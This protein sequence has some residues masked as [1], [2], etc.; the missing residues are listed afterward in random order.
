MSLDGAGE[1]SREAQCIKEV[2]YSLINAKGTS[3]TQLQ[4]AINSSLMQLAKTNF[5]FVTTAVFS[6][7]ENQNASDQQK[8]QLL[9]LLCQVL[10]QRE[11]RS[12]VVPRTLAKN[13]TRL[14][15]ASPGSASAD[16]LCELAPMHPDLVLSEISQ[17]LAAEMPSFAL[18]LLAQ[19]A[20]TS[21]HSLSE[22]LNEVLS[23]C[24]SLLQGCRVMDLRLLLLRTWCSLCIAIV[25]CSFRD[26]D[27]LDAGHP[28][29]SRQFAIAA[30]PMRSRQTAAE[31]DGRKTTQ[32][33]SAVFALLMSSWTNWKDLAL[34]VVVI[35]TL[36]HLSLVIP[37][38]Q[39]LTNAD[40]LLEHIISLLSKQGLASSASP[41]PPFALMRGTC[42]TLQA[43]VDADRELLTIE[44]T[45]QTLWSGLF[46]AVVA[47]GPLQYLQ[48]LGQEALQ[49]Q[50]ELLRCMDVLAEN[51]GKE[52]LNFL[53]QKVKGHREERLAALLV[54]R[55]L[56]AG[57][58]A[59]TIV[60]GVQPLLSDSDAAVGLMLG[61]LLVAS[62]TLLEVTGARQAH[63][64]NLIGFVIRLTA[65]AQASEGEHA[66][67][68]IPKFVSKGYSHNDAPSAE[69][70]RKRAGSVLGQLAGASR[71][72]TNLVL[73]PLLL[74]ALINPSML[75]GLPVLCR[76]VT[77]MVQSERDAAEQ[78]AVSSGG[79][80]EAIQKFGQSEVLLLWMLIC[81]HAPTEPP[82]IGISILRCLESLAT[83][84]HPVLGQIWEAPSKRLQTLCGHLEEAMSSGKLEGDL[85]VSA[86]AQE[87]DFF[88]SALAD[89]DDLPGKL[90]EILC[91]FLVEKVKKD[92]ESPMAKP[93]DVAGGSCDLTDAQRAGVFNL[94]GICLRHSGNSQR[95]ASTLELL[96]S[97]ATDLGRTSRR[98]FARGLGVCA[99]RHLELTLTA[100]AKAAKPDPTRRSGLQSF[101]GKTSAVQTAEQLRATL[102]L[103]L[104]FCAINTP[105]PMLLQEKACERILKPLH[106]ALVQ[107]KSR[108]I[109]RH[110]VDAVR[111]VGDA[112]RCP[113]ERRMECDP[114]LT[115]CAEVSLP[116]LL[117]ALSEDS[118]TREVLTKYRNDLL[119]ALL[120]LITVPQDQDAEKMASFDELL[121]P[122]L[123]A[124]SSFTLLPLQLPS[125]LFGLLVEH[126]LQVLLVSL[127]IEAGSGGSGGV[128]RVKSVTSVM[129]ALLFH[130]H[131]WFGISKLLQDVHK[132][133]AK[134]HNEAVRW[135]CMQ[136]IGELCRAAPIVAV[137]TDGEGHNDLGDWCECLA[138][139]LPRVGDSS[140]AVASASIDCMQQLLARCEFTATLRVGSLEEYLTLPQDTSALLDEID[141]EFSGVTPLKEESEELRGDPAPVSQQLVGSLLQRLPQVMPAMV[142]QLMPA[143]HDVDSHAAMTGV[144]AMH[145]LLRS[146][147]LTVEATANIVSS[148][149]EEV[150][151][152]RHSSVR[153]LVLSC[154][155][156][157][158]MHHFDI[159]IEELLETGPDFNMS[160]MGALQVMAKENTLLL[161]L[162][163]HFAAI[164]NY[165]DPGPPEDPSRKVLAAT[166]ALGHLFTVNDST[167]G[168][169]VKKYFS[170]LFGTF[171]LRIGTTTEGLS[172]QQAAG[173][174]M[175]FLH[176]SQNDSMAMALEG[177]RL[178]KVTKEFYDEVICELVTLYCPHQPRRRET[179]LHFLQPFLA[180]QPEGHRVA[181]ATTMSQVLLSC[182][183]NP[184]DEEVMHTTLCSVVA[185]I[186]DP[187]ATVRKQAVRGLGNV[188]NLWHHA[189]EAFGHLTTEETIQEVLRQMCRLLSDEASAVRREAVVAMQRA[190]QVPSL[191]Q[192]WRLYLLINSPQ[193]LPL[194]LD[195]EDTLLRGASL[196]L[197]G[198]LCELATSNGN[199][200]QEADFSFAGIG[201]MPQVSLNSLDVFT[202]SLLM[203]VMQCTIRLED[204]SSAV[205]AAAS[206]CLRHITGTYVFQCASSSQGGSQE[207]EEAW[208]LL[209]RWEQA[210]MDFEQFIFP[211]M[212]VL[213]IPRREDLA[214]KR[215]QLCQR[216]L[217]LKPQ[218][219]LPPGAPPRTAAGFAAIALLRQLQHE[220]LRPSYQVC[221]ICEDL[222]DLLSIEDLETKTQA[223]RL[224]GLLDLGESS[225]KMPA[226]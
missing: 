153:Q 142:Q 93:W 176:A 33:V 138:L 5:D 55:Q 84:L 136:I 156:V 189:W 213:H 46:S 77:Q 39:F 195:A 143:M 167:M 51:F 103:S 107:E 179:L 15:L 26:I 204:S 127:P 191:P 149:F 196:D 83:F 14:L 197:L 221:S 22:R 102:L 160:I 200:A 135:T 67:G 141:V 174:F 6:A 114:F 21:P 106:Q 56:A 155:K 98:A 148:I 171:L 50:A 42:L 25:M 218:D 111:L 88:L 18:E 4:L 132:V 87:M 172:A 193:H 23:R 108:D 75:L 7:L 17:H 54:L 162:L 63:V 131:N 206:R 49:S 123:D 159:V 212:A 185:A 182:I 89:H 199:A 188:A 10:E 30:A 37:K 94:A 207:A 8:L 16:V 79:I 105:G 125:E 150:E 210:Q 147:E 134:S 80:R 65:R 112:Y 198:R 48:G 86:M 76:C 41:M 175:N 12:L 215:L 66:S 61:E 124:I 166:V 211:F 194:L 72:S 205:A 208:E 180:A 217:A 40:A 1:I 59:G 9:R 36:G 216:Y 201:E 99:S 62:P 165:T 20:E 91:G 95:A 109:L 38:D 224:L 90:T 222:L 43:C 60:E 52:S 173:A 154:I 163:N 169:A 177:N 202:D 214:L 158:A 137:P 122:S 73:W 116:S 117:S 146:C 184:M 11:P 168:A 101:F 151:K 183:D 68:Y 31:A 13:M 209:Q 128:S 53:L 57:P 104:G 157:L 203:M 2:V 170:Q 44:N 130:V 145:L 69:E 178:A 121:C 126:T 97:H 119:E 71:T 120:P 32:V 133:G 78:G 96:V 110:A 100:I 19:V 3:S 92:R 219:F 64:N 190:C 70:V 139:L 81:A 140:K 24:F 34:R 82:G 223:A 113:P 187:D 226:V 192:T 152:V 186:E 118:P 225:G 144:D 29:F 47:G 28:N 161:K 181:A 35:D 129:K 164:L 45:L 85:W 115:D 27:P 220:N 58:L 74:K